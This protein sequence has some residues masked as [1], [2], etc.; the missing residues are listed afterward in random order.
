M[1]KASITLFFLSLTL[2]CVTVK[3]ADG[4]AI[5]DPLLAA[6]ARIELGLSYLKTGNTVRAKQNLDLALQYAPKYV[7]ATSAIAYY[8]Q[9][10]LETEQAEDWYL[11]A[12]RLS[13]NDGNLL[14]DYGVFLCRQQRYQKAVQQF[15][16]AIQQPGYSRVAVSYEN[17]GLCTLKLEQ[18]YRA[19]IYFTKSLQHQPHRYR[20]DIELVR[21]AIRFG[22]IDRAQYRLDRIQTRVGIT[23]E[24][25]QLRQALNAE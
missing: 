9:Q 14:N 6:D 4:N 13:P 17:A 19:E 23:P 12:I 3:R 1:F 16:Q 8:Y 10:V 25:E 22:Q 11:R 7:R 18:W 24:V 5:F 21:L 20:S 2:G 15:K